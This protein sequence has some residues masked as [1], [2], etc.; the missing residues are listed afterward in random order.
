MG[1]LVIAIGISESSQSSAGAAPKT[2][3]HPVEKVTICHF[4]SI[5]AEHPYNEI[6]IDA[7]QIVNGNGHGAHVYDIWP[8]FQYRLHDGTIVTVPSH[9]NQEILRNH[10]RIPGE[11]TET[12]SP[13]PTVTVTV[14]ATPDWK[15]HPTEHPTQCP[16]ATVTATATATSTVTSTTTATATATVTGPT[17]TVTVTTP[18]VPSTDCPPPNLVN[19]VRGTGK[20]DNLVGTPCRDGMLGHKGNDLMLGAAAND[21][22]LGGRGRDRL[23]GGTGTDVL[24]GG[25]NNDILV[26]NDGTP[27]DRLIGGQGQ[28]LCII[29]PGD[30]AKSCERTITR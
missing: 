24:R 5:H 14:T 13:C 30:K 19:V 27:G 3:T 6:T 12:V 4:T 10:C 11:P 25:F 20:N 17:S 1:I 28:D 18:F 9:G 2:G 22:L 7:K 21:V 15:T 8:T 26:S 23:D 29:D 16:T